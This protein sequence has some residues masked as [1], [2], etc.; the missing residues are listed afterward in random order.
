MN[1]QKIQIIVAGI[2]IFL[3][4]TG[5]GFLNQKEP[6]IKY[7]N[8]TEIKYEPSPFCHPNFTKLNEIHENIQNITPIPTSNVDKSMYKYGGISASINNPPNNA[9]ISKEL[10]EKN[11]NHT[12]AIDEFG[13]KY[14]F[15][16]GWG[17]FNQEEYNVLPY[18][19][20]L[21]DVSP[22]WSLI[23]N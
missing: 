23:D 19:N 13:N 14:Y 12:I 22:Y 16:G 9:I 21:Y 11:N 15:V 6:E 18:K 1:K 4:G 3:L 5:V 7:V 8:I 17:W 20:K 2:V 10:T